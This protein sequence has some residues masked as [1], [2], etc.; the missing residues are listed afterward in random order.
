MLRTDRQI[1]PQILK[2][3][4]IVEIVL[5]EVSFDMFDASEEKK[6][7]VAMT[8]INIGELAKHLSH[9]FTEDDVIPELKYAARTRDMY[10]HGYATL[11][12]PMVYQTAT[13]SGHPE[14]AEMSWYTISSTSKGRSAD[15]RPA[16][17]IHPCSQAL[18]FSSG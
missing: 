9:E 7:A 4:E 17:Q 12:F 14:A 10:V 18:V 5:H 2:E 13:E 16:E 6:R 8:V 3:I 11:S 15:R 1:L